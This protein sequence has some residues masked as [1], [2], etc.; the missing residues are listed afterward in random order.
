MTKLGDVKTI[1]LTVKGLDCAACAEKIE[2]VLMRHEG[3]K[4]ITVY[5]GAEKADVQFDPFLIKEKL[6]IDAINSLG[7]KVL[8]EKEEALQKNFLKGERTFDLLR[9]GFVFLLIVLSLTG[10]T[11]RLSPIDI[12]SIIAIVVGGYP[13]IKHAYIDLREKAITANVFMALGVVAATVI[14]EFRSAAIIAFFM[15]ISEFIDS[16]TMEKSRKAIK[17]LID[18]APKTARVKIGDTE[19]EIP[20]EEVKKGDIVVVKPGEKIPVEGVIISG[21]GSVNQATITGESIPVEKKEGDIVYAATI[22]QLG[23]LFIKVTH[24]GQDTTYARII[25]LVEEAESSKAPVQRVADKFAAYFTPAILAISV[26]TFLITWKITNAIAVIVVA[27]PCTVAIA[28]PLAVVAS[29]GK[30]AKRGIIIKGGR[31]LE[32]L[33]KVD[34]I[35]M[36]KTGTVTMGDP[37]VTNIKGFAEH[38]DKEIISYAAGVERYSDHPLAKAIIK[39]ASEMG[40]AVPEPEQYKV[41][42]GMGIQAVVNDKTIIVGSREMLRDKNIILSEGIEKYIIEKEEEGK[43]ALLLS[44]DS[45]LCGVICVADI[46]R[47][48]S[49]EAI[50]SLKRLGFDDPIMLTGDNPRTANA[51]ASS[52]GIKNVMAQLLPEDKLE[53]IKNLESSGRKVLMVGDGINDAPA[54]ARAYVGIAMGAVG[55]DAAIE[56]SDV[57]L[58]RDEWKQI[59]E[60]VM[61]G[62]KTFSIIKQN[63]AVGII[64]NLVGIALASTGILSPAM[65]AVAH[66]M[67]DV[68]VFLNSLRL[69]K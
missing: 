26:L 10:I 57:A 16:F 55:S 24:T 61:I 6:I 53:A 4:G 34:T 47:E 51:I 17:D 36:D 42:P 56:A 32:A 15:L 45:I 18:M 13:L 63:L 39:K 43:T 69:L 52:L 46:I 19:V 3:V 60:A 14:G 66:V 5:L 28:T 1:S 48:E 31:Y 8:T 27:C 64:F 12:F 33:A 58:M 35:V 20:V 65:A 23:V 22:N 62:R 54:L 67:P 44:H 25:K 29:M 7:Y 40:V 30:A 41:I 11:K 59:P 49:I 2:K 21:R 9:I 50:A 38:D 37:V 68:L